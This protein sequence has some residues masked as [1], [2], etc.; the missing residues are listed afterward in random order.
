MTQQEAADLT[1]YAA[2]VGIFCISPG[3]CCDDEGSPPVSLFLNRRGN[4]VQ[5]WDD[6]TN[7]DN[8]WRSSVYGGQTCFSLQNMRTGLFLRVRE[9]CADLGI[10]PDL[11]Q[12]PEQLDP[13]FTWQI[14]QWKNKD[15]YVL[16]NVASQTYLNVAGGRM[17]YGNKVHMWDNPDEDDSQWS[18]EA[19]P[20]ET[21]AERS[22]NLLGL[23]DAEEF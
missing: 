19:A 13:S 16:R 1:I 7:P 5:L 18:F 4:L 23:L 22:A 15:T 20:N 11:E 12:L 14:L 9:G 21:V 10:R 8:Q 17:H 2:P 6:R 3:D